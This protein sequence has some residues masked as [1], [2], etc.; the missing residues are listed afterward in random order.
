MLP[1]LDMM[2]VNNAGYRPAVRRALAKVSVPQYRVGVRLVR[3][4]LIL[5]RPANKNAGG[6]ISAVGGVQQRDETERGCIR[7]A[8]VEGIVVVDRIA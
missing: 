7:V 4:A 3:I 2:V 8:R 5:V 6:V 1:L